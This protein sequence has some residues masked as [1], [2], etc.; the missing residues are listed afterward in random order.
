MV[1]DMSGLSIEVI[2]TLGELFAQGSD[3]PAYELF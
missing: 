3:F 2:E 1:G